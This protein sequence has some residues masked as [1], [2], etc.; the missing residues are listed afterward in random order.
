MRSLKKERK[1]INL[2]FIILYNN[3]LNFKSEVFIILLFID[4]W[5]WLWGETIFIDTWHWRGAHFLDTWHWRGVH[6]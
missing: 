3:Y 2:I 4:T 1:F 5:H 6:F